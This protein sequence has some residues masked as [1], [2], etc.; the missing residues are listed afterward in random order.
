MRYDANPLRKLGDS[1][2]RYSH[3]YGSLANY[4]FQPLTQTSFRRFLVVTAA[5]SLK[6]GAKVLLFFECAKFL[7]SFFSKKRIFYSFSLLSALL[8]SIKRGVFA[9]HPS[10]Y[11]AV[12]YGERSEFGGEM[13]ADMLEVF[14][15]HL[16]HIARVSQEY[17]ASFLVLCHI[18]VLAFLELFQFLF[19]IA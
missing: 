4:W 7:G 3:P 16:Q 17:I 6:C 5:F 9:A 12:G 2:P 11:V 15:C 1:N 10:F 8:F 19:V 18:L 13:E 14:L